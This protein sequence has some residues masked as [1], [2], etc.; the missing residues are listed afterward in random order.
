ML[1]PLV[2]TQ[3]A[4]ELVGQ[5]RTF[6]CYSVC[7]RLQHKHIYCQAVFEYYSQDNETG[8]LPTGR[9]LSNVLI[10]QSFDLDIGRIRVLSTAQLENI[11][12]VKCFNEQTSNF[13]V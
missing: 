4:F 5:V 10:N 8:L 7:S 1:P 13:K 9:D 12:V 2:A 6:N 11:H 3:T